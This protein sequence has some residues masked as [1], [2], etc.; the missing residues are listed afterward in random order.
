MPSEKEVYNSHAQQ[1]ELLIR[2][3]DYKNNIPA[4]INKITPIDGLDIVE[5]GAGTGRLT[6]FLTG[7]ARSLAACD[8]SL[9]MLLKAK[10]IYSN[11]PKNHTVLAVADMR[12]VPCASQS[13]DMVIAGWSFCYL[14]VWGG[15]NWQLALEK[16]LAETKRLLRPG[17][18]MTFS[19]KL[20]HRL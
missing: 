1:Y 13:V 2:R 4:E 12:A 15:N 16:G 8:T 18:L 5:L 17:G 11:Y 14:A 7:K 3:E 9:Q 19:G 6:R 10:T 20:R